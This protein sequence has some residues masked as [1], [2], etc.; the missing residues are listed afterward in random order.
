MLLANSPAI[1]ETSMDEDSDNSQ[2]IL[3]N[4]SSSP[5]CKVNKKSSYYLSL[6]KKYQKK[7]GALYIKKQ[8]I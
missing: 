3:S 7:D 1:I 5:K 6:D 4:Q 8:E 2:M